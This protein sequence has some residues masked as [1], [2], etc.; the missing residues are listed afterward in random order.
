WAACL[1]EAA[2]I[3][4]S[5]N[6]TSVATQGTLSALSWTST[7]DVKN[8]MSPIFLLGWALSVSGGL[9]RLSCYRTLGRFFTFEVA[10]R[11]KHRLITTGPYAWVRH[12]SYTAGITETAGNTICLFHSGS[13]VRESGVLGTRWGSA[14]ACVLWIWDAYLVV[15]VCR[16]M[17]QEDQ[18]LRKHFG[19]QWDDWATKVP[20]RLM[21]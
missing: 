20:Y 14:I 5:H 11:P 9:V 13:W 15:S 12:P 8:N 18:I 21:P 17:P 19:K 10:V 7:Q 4:A 1:S 3:L 2:T 16:R 6:A